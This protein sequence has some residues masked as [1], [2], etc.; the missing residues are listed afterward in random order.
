MEGNHIEAAK[1]NNAIT[2]A[3]IMSD[4]IK[5][6][7]FAETRVVSDKTFPRYSIKKVID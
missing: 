7:V 2:E 6:Q 1:K 4:G 3:F 5:V